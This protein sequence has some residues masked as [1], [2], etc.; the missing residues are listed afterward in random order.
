MS[1]LLLFIDKTVENKLQMNLHRV[2]IRS[3]LTESGIIK[4]KQSSLQKINYAQASF[5]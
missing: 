3:Q 5:I 4:N 1:A 2:D